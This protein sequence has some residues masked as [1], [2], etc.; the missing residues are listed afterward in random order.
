MMSLRAK[1]RSGSGTQSWAQRHTNRF[2]HCRR[3]LGS[4]LRI[5]SKTVLSSAWAGGRG[6]IRMGP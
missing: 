4:V 3:R 6:G 2:Q 1:L 5:L